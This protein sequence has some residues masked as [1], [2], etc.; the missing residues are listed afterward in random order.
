VSTCPLWRI[1]DIRLPYPRSSILRYIQANIG[2][3]SSDQNRIPRSRV[4]IE[5]LT[6][7]QLLKKFPTLHRI[8]RF[9]TM[10]TKSCQLTISCIGWLLPTPPYPVS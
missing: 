5:K 10:F 2:I 4:L 8:Q 9:T 6:V 3:I 1:F 7:A